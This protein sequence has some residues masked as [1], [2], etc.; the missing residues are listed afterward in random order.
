M[1]VDDATRH[2]LASL[3]R[4]PHKRK[5]KFSRDTPTVWRPHQVRNP[6][7]ALGP[8]HD[9]FT[10]AG[11]WELI[12][13]RLE[14]GHDVEAVKLLKPA[15]GTGYVMKIML[16]ETRPLLYVK[17]QLRHGVILGRSFHYSERN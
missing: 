5:T 16:E 15:G 3:A 9:V 4:R 1:S 13:S 6:D 2:Q 11:A 8:P 17:L 14:H 10:D 12:A 7:A